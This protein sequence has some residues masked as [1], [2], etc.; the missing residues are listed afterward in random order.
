MPL[1][2]RI[3]Y[4]VSDKVVSFLSLGAFKQRLDI[5]VGYYEKL[6]ISLLVCIQSYAPML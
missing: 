1:N 5:I 4:F 3:E 6:T 2:H